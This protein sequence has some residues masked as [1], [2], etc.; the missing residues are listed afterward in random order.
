MTEKLNKTVVK[1]ID[2]LGTVMEK[3]EDIRV[4]QAVID[5]SLNPI[6]DM[7]TLLENSLPGGINDKDEMDARSY[8]RSNW[9]NLV[10]MSEKIGK[11]LSSHQTEYLKKLKTNVKDLVKD[12]ADFRADYEKNGPMVEG[13]SPKEAIERLKRFD[14]QYE[15]RE[16][17]F[18]IN[19]K[20]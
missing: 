2:S 8:L 11:N 7:Y 1:D 6:A 18:K 14:E 4:F 9:N 13:I 5:I 17:Q 15:V 16:Q 3:L 12:V 10:E 20:G 19:K